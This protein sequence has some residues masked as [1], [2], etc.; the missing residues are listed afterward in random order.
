MATPILRR[1]LLYVPASSPKM[2]Q[3]TLSLSVD[4]VTYDLEDS[5]AVSQKPAARKA[6]STFLTQPRPPHIN[7]VSV[8]INSIASGMAEADLTALVSVSFRVC[9]VLISEAGSSQPRRHSRSE[10][11]DGGRSQVRN[12]YRRTNQ[13]PGTHRVCSCY[14]EY[15]LNLYEPVPVWPD[16]CRRG[17]CSRLVPYEDTLPQ[18]VLIRPERSGY[19]GGSC[20]DTLVDRSCTYTVWKRRSIERRGIGWKG[21]GIQWQ[22]GDTSQ[23]DQA[24]PRGILSQR[25]RNYVGGENC[26]C[27]RKGRCNGQ[28][29]MGTRWDDD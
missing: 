6:L 12:G 23:S 27:C 10:G 22:A 26:H 13:D 29:L 8:R 25:R 18:R 21:I 28:G 20:K 24:S 4:T 16:L 17:F 7:E 3:K 2:L 5:V 9:P 14:P 1:A 15:T 11:L 19:S